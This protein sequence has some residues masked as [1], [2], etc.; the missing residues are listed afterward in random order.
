MFLTFLTS[1]GLPSVKNSSQPTEL[2]PSTPSSS[3]HRKAVLVS[4]L[5]AGVLLILTCIAVISGCLV[6]HKKNSNNEELLQ[7]FNKSTHTDTSKLADKEKDAASNDYDI[8]VDP[9]NKPVERDNSLKYAYISVANR[10][11]S[12]FAESNPAYQAME[13]NQ[14]GDVPT[15]FNP[16]YEPVQIDRANASNSMSQEI[17]VYY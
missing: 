15:S 2:T 14:S 6:Y 16:A 17:H 12:V 7:S 5:V 4:T 3:Q 13:H 1:S 9:A 10:D 8:V 11:S